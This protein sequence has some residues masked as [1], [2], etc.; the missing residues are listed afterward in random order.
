MAFYALYKWYSPWSKRGYPDM[1]AWYRRKLYEEWLDSLPP[2]ERSAYLKRKEAK[3]KSSITALLCMNMMMDAD[4]VPAT[5]TYKTEIPHEEFNIW[6]DGEL[7][8]VGIVFS[9]KDLV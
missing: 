7:Y 3:R 4:G 6:E 8:C 5:W 1:I 2:E 9:I